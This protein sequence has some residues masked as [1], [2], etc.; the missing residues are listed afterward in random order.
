MAM[1]G[2]DA[3][4][5]WQLRL[6]AVLL[7]SRQRVWISPSHRQAGRKSLYQ[8]VFSHSRAC[9]VVVLAIRFAVV[10]RRPVLARGRT[11]GI[12]VLG[13]IQLGRFDGSWATL[14]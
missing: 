14:A 11:R 2:F 13:G 6:L 5:G 10:A 12:Q 8:L 4:L 3:Q 9:A 7:Q 1:V